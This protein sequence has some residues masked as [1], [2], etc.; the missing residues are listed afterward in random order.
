MNGTILMNALSKM[1]IIT[2][3]MI[4][5]CKLTF[6]DTNT[7]ASVYEYETA[8]RCVGSIFEALKAGDIVQLKEGYYRLD[9]ELDLIK[10]NGLESEIKSSYFVDLR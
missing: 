10:I 1:S 6:N 4:D 5:D 8:D 7:L 2:K 3:I 9:D